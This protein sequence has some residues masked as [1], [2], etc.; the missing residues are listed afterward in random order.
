MVL[1]QDILSSPRHL[2]LRRAQEVKAANL[3]ASTEAAVATGDNEVPNLKTLKPGEAMLYSFFTPSLASGRYE[4]NS[5][6]EIV[7]NGVQQDPD[8]TKTKKVFNV[9]SPQ[10]TLPE[11]LV[12]SIYPPEGAE[13][14]PTILPHVLFTDPFFPWERTAVPQTPEE[15]KKDNLRKRVPWLAVLVFSASEL[16][17]DK[18]QLMGTSSIFTNSDLAKELGTTGNVIKM[19]VNCAIDMPVSDFAPGKVAKSWSP[20]PLSAKSDDRTKA[21]FVPR[22]LFTQLIATYNERGE[23]IVDQKS[24]DLS[25]YTYL[26]H[27]RQSAAKGANFSSTEDG[28]FSVVHSH[29]AA[30]LDNQQISRAI[31]HLV[32]LEG[33]HDKSR[34]DF[35]SSDYIMLSS[36]YSWSY[37]V[38]PA[39][40]P[41]VSDSLRNLGDHCAVLGPPKEVIQK[42]GQDT[43][44]SG[45]RIAARLRDGY[46]IVKYR[47]QTGEETAAIA[48]GACIPCVPPKKL[49]ENW[50]SL[51]FSGSNLQILDK[52]LGLMDLTYSMA[53][54][55]GRTLALADRSFTIALSRLRSVIAAMALRRGKE[56]E[57]EKHDA[58]KSTKDTISSL[59]KSLQVLADAEAG[60]LAPSSHDQPTSGATE[61]PLTQPV[62]LSLANP[63]IVST[64]KDVVDE[65]IRHLAGSDDETGAR[66]YNELNLPRSSDWVTVMTF[67]M[68]R[69]F[70][71]GIPAQNL[72]VEP[73]WLP[74]ES[75]RFFYIDPHWV[76]AVIDGALGV[77]NHI[78]RN[79]DSLRRSIK[80]IFNKYFSTVDPDVGYRPQVPTYGLLLRSKIVKDFPDLLITAPIPSGSSSKDDGPHA[81]ERAEILRQERIAD[82]VILC[83]FDRQPGSKSLHTLTF[84]QPAHQQY[85]ALG[86]TL[87]ATQLTISFTRTFS[88]PRGDSKYETIAKQT[89]Y[90]D[91]H[92][93]PSRQI[94]IWGQ[95]SELRFL[96]LTAF[97]NEVKDI[98]QHDGTEPKTYFDDDEVTSSLIGY[99]LGS[100]VYQ[101]GLTSDRLSLNPNAETIRH[102]SFSLMEV[103]PTA[104]R[105]EFFPNVST[106]HADLSSTESLSTKVIADLPQEVPPHFPSLLSTFQ[107]FPEREEIESLPP[108][109][110]VRRVAAMR[111]M[112]MLALASPEDA[113][114]AGKPP[115][116]TVRVYPQMSPFGAIPT[117]SPYPLDLIFAIRI[118]VM[119]SKKPYMYPHQLGQITISIP[120]GPAN[121]RQNPA[122]LSSYHGPGPSMLQNLRFNVIASQGTATLDLTLLPRSTKG[123][124]TIGHMR[125]CSFI[126]PMVTVN[127][128]DDDLYIPIKFVASYV[129]G[130]DQPKSPKLHLVP[131]D[132]TVPG[133]PE[134]VE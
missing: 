68:H 64:M 106:L 41:S 44:E 19:D 121:D 23:E 93:H 72:L 58:W 15:L 134:G 97:G 6:Q 5:W 98:I 32:S 8:T 122:L 119:D 133:S 1:S 7:A 34:A 83:L 53:W 50:T 67:I 94:F 107:L 81:E 123:Y 49:S 89:F 91:A 120:M 111:S 99:Q 114:G 25:R 100:H 90:A 75:L 87:S 70:L 27:V 82:D 130:G 84:T 24:I 14:S 37:N 76:E 118:P 22:P 21:I 85:F 102:P 10:Y 124:V 129:L 73:S 59:A 46:T 26:A 9:E 127:D 69:M 131:Q 20:V 39:G 71:I 36:L 65:H 116:F 96:N 86:D 30:P 2:T 113:G 55:L 115:P 17:L 35:A 57:M 112:A 79:D 66:L 109:A 12:H 54:N 105:T 43:S 18:D 29:R 132:K 95:N 125:E 61:K 33:L 4:V 51:S 60:S 128:Y 108:I 31:V 74:A 38:L 77:A 92:T 104:E 13:A 103:D 78:E 11:N 45:Q 110:P 42:A 101:L 3:A 40:A 56:K 47:T 52:D 16:R 80:G 28:L 88:K 63:S 62:D 48:R 126:L 117:K